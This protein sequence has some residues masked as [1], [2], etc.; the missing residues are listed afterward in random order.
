MV[1]PRKSGNKLKNLPCLLCPWLVN[2]RYIR[3]LL[4]EKRQRYVTGPSKGIW[5]LVK[6]TQSI[7]QM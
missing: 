3:C 1:F 2:S 4:G 6:E 5:V 7:K